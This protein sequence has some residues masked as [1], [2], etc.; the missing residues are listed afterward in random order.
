L[1]PVE[2]NDELLLVT[3]V[4]QLIRVP[5]GQIRVAGRNTQGVT[6]F[7]T[8]EKEHVVSVE[9][10]EGAADEAVAED[11]AMDDGSGDDGADETPAEGEAL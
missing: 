1:F 8:T 11:G 3:D 9:R 5:V 4:G 10:L 2:D 7:R 6:I